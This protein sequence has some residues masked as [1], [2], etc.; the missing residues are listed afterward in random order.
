MPPTNDGA[1]DGDGDGDGEIMV[2]WVCASVKWRGGHFSYVSHNADGMLVCV[3][4]LSWMLELPVLW[5]GWWRWATKRAWVFSLEEKRR[6]DGW[7]LRWSD[8]LQPRWM[9]GCWLLSRCSLQLPLAIRRRMKNHAWMIFLFDIFLYSL[10]RKLIC[11]T[12][13][14]N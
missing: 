4:V 12:H 3:Y 5:R 11:L 6:I 8:G 9:D 10:E 13:N 2:D 7:G 14:L 1:Y